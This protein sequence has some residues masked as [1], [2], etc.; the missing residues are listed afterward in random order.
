MNNYTPTIGLEVHAELKTQTKMFCGCKNDPSEQHPSLNVCPVCLGHPGT[1]PTINK[2]AVKLVIRAGLAIGA[3]INPVTKFDRKNYFYPDLPKGYQIS[4]YDQPLVLGGELAGVEI[5]RIHLEEDAG[6]LLHGSNLP[7]NDNNH[8]N[9][10]SSYRHG[11]SS[12][13][14]LVDYNRTG[15]PLMELV[16]EPV[17]KSAAQAVA[18]AKEYQLLLRYI[19]V[20]DAD[21]ERGQMRFDANVSLSATDKLGTRSEIKNLNSFAALEAAV[22]YEIKRQAEVLDSGKEV[23]QETRGWDPVKLATKSQRSK[24]EAH[25]Y[26]YFPEPD[27]PS[28]ETK[29]FDI[30]RLRA[31]MPELPEAKRRRF[32]RE[33][34]LSSAQA[35]S[36]VADKSLADFFES[37]VSELATRDEL[38][39]S[40]IEKRPQEL[41]YNYLTSDLAGLMNETGVPFGEIKINPEE[42]AHLVDL[43]ADGKIMSRQ[44]KDILRKM[45]ETGEDP[46]TILEAEGLHTVSDEGEL[47][48]TVREVIAENPAAV[49]DYKKGKAASLQFL[50][51]KGMS[52]L[53]GKGN[54]G[55]LKQLF[56]KE[57]S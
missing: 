38:S 13:Y 39:T 29:E 23:H 35:D 21:L 33:F 49:A 28:F 42:L 52:K 27:L 50:I 26:R 37:A 25:D 20:S 57:L 10:E 17:I 7:H 30:E 43:I 40:K 36:L 55:V 11:Q 15:V 5:T 53:K 4:Q 45:F 6:K 24:E 2:E 31:E 46:E 34:G 22:N 8:N 47:E 56:E 19:G 1:L 14:S 18:F 48:G 3:K 9:D 44:A 32:A 16:T 41:L 12:S 51:G 54:P